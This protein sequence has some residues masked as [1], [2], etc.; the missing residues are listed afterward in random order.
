MN[1]KPSELKREEAIETA[2]LT[3]VYNQD[4]KTAS[5]S[6]MRVTSLK[7]CRRVK[8]PDPLPEKEEAAIQTVITAVEAAITR[9]AQ[10]N[11]KL[12]FKPSTLSKSEAMGK[13]Q[14]K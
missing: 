9:E 12:R 4:L 8:I 11:K 7:T 10:R 14:I 1:D 2:L 6:N 3:R 5:F 13:T